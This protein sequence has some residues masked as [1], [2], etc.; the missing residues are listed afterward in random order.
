M[1]KHAPVLLQI[2]RACTSKK[3]TKSSSDSNRVIG[4]CAAV[5]FKHHRTCMSLVQKLISAILHSGHSSKM[6][7]AVYMIAACVMCIISL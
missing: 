7:C 1:E 5:I 4:V 2:L 3:I 6:V